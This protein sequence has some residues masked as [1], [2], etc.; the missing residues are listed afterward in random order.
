MVFPQVFVWG[1]M[2]S[3]AGA[4]RAAAQ[5]FFAQK[6]SASIIGRPSDFIWGGGKLT[7]AWPAG[8]DDN[9][10]SRAEVS[11]VP[12]L[13]VNGDLDFATP[14]QNPT[15]ELMPYLLLKDGRTLEAAISAGGLPMLAAGGH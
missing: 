4:D 13:V 11:R 14:P 12:M 7:S 5:R 2:A 15:R 3:I 9:A 6:D 8:P 1:E 10:Y